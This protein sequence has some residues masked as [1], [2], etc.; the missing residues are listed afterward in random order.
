MW[1]PCGCPVSHPLFSSVSHCWSHIVQNLMHSKWRHY[2]LFVLPVVENWKCTLHCTMHNA[3]CTGERRGRPTRSRT[4]EQRALITWCITHHSHHSLSWFMCQHHHSSPGKPLINPII[5]II[6][7]QHW[8]LTTPAWP[9]IWMY[10]TLN[11]LN[12]FNVL[13]MQNNVQ[14][15]QV[16]TT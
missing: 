9:T 6:W 4:N 14:Y 13:V 11:K 5:N 3:Q 15:V 16:V 1:L 12:I 7:P 2:T 8:I 10:S